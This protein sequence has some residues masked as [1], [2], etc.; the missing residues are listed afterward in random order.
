MSNRQKIL[1]V[2]LFAVLGFLALQVPVA[3]LKGSRAAFTLFDLFGPI[4]GG[5]LGG[6]GGALAVAATQLGNILYHP[7]TLPMNIILIRFLTPMMAAWYFSRKNV[8]NLVVPVIAIIAFIANPIGIKV[9]YFAILWL[10]PIACYFWQPRRSGR[11]PDSASSS[12]DQ[13]LM[14]RALGATFAAHAV[15]GALWIWTWNTTTAYWTGLIPIVIKERLI[16]AAGIALSYLLM[17]NILALVARKIP[18]VAFLVNSRY[19]LLPLM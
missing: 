15:G 14:A 4:A 2:V 7:A 3:T 12:G 6:L 1:F 13:P 10:I 18:R 19:S 8:F 9:W 17:N 16:F 11:G 5:F